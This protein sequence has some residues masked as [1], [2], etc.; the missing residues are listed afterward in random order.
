MDICDSRVAFATEKVV[1]PVS[2]ETKEI[3]VSYQKLRSSDTTLLLFHKNC[4]TS[5]YICEHVC[6]SNKEYRHRNRTISKMG[7]ISEIRCLWIF[8]DSA[9]V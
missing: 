2:N 5:F 1:A 7:V 9:S 8:C 4:H 3:K 6:F